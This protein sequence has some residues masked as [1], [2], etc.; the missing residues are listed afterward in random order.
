MRYTANH[1]EY[2]IPVKPKQKRAL[3]DSGF[4]TEKTI[5]KKEKELQKER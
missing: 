3:R 2:S 5:E 1:Y 4:E